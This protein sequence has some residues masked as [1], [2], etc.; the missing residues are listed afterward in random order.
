MSVWLKSGSRERNRA[1]VGMALESWKKSGEASVA[2]IRDSG[3]TGA[4]KARGDRT[5]S[6][7]PSQVF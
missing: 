6:L 1:Q 5:K 7:C 4:V 2:G 3:E